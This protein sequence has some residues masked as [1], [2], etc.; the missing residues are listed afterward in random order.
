[1]AKL[2]DALVSGTSDGNIV[3]VR[4]LLRAL[5]GHSSFLG[6]TFFCFAGTYA[7][8]AHGALHIC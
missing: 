7:P 4:V 5:K 1:M 3:Q 8:D 2:V 6:M